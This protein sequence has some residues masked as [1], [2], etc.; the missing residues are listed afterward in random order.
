MSRQHVSTQTQTSL[1]FSFPL[2]RLSVHSFQFLRTEF[3]KLK[4]Y[5]FEQRRKVRGDSV[6]AISR[7]TEYQQ[8]TS[9]LSNQGKVSLH[10][11]IVNASNI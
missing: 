4:Q 6:N 3:E 8:C 10:T 1:L 7:D 2:F 5:V 9:N 11:L